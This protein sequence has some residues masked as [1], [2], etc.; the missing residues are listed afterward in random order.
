MNPDYLITLMCCIDCSEDEQ[1]IDKWGKQAPLLRLYAYDRKRAIAFR[2][3]GK[4][5]KALEHE[6]R[7]DARY[8]AVQRVREFEGQ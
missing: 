5:A 1:Q 4:I 3:V 6:K 7:N 8:T 2:R